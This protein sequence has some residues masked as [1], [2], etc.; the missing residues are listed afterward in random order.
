MKNKLKSKGFWLSLSG[1]IIVLLQTLGVKFDVVYLNEVVSAVCSLLIVVGIM[2]DD[3][4]IKD[5]TT[6]DNDV[7]AD[8]SQFCEI[9]TSESENEKESLAYITDYLS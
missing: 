8:V 4:K 5:K 7:S 1:A 6:K 9:A 2:V 3:V